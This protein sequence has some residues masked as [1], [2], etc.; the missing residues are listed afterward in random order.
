MA[1][2]KKTPAKNEAKDA[3]PKLVAMKRGE[4]WPE[5]HIADVHPDEVENYAV[6]GWVKA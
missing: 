5:P 2:A 1:A 4:E 6:G 3:A